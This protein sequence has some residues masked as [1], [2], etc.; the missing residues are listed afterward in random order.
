MI[1]I[2]TNVFSALM[3]AVP[4]PKVIA[5]LDRQSQTAVWTTS[6]TVFE[7]R[8]GLQIMA[9]GKRRSALLQAF[10]SL[11]RRIEHRVASFD[12]AAASQA[13]DL[14]ASRQNKGRPI[15]LRDTMIAG[16]VL[17]RQAGIATRNTDHFSDISATVINPWNA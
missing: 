3:Q 14:M 8:F 17:A 16:I 11:L 5:W 10:E 13:A 9:G 4:E 7:I 1:V 12:D 6:V 2:D 15:D